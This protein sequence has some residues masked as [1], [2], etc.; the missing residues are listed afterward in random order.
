MNSC[1]NCVCL[2]QFPT[3]E[4]IDKSFDDVVSMVVME[5]SY[6]DGPTFPEF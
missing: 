2:D 6:W 3:D 5:T 4:E 1:G